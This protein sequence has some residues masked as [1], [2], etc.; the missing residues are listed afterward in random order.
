M[1]ASLWKQLF[2]G[3]SD[4]RHWSR[5]MASSKTSP[6]M[7]DFKNKAIERKHHKHQHKMTK[8]TWTEGVGEEEAQSEKLK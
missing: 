5:L 4:C 6:K 1:F 2:P 3:N 8:S 7:E